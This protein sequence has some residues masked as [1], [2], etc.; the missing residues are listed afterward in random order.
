MVPKAIPYKDEI[1]QVVFKLN[2]NSSTGPDGL[3]GRFYQVCWNIIGGDIRR[4]AVYFF[5]GNILPKYIRNTNL[6]LIPKKDN[7]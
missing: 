2:G 6:V 4:L 7:M 5:Q 1:K 3:T